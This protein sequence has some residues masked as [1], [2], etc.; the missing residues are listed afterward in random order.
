[1]DIENN[2]DDSRQKNLPKKKKQTIFNIAARKSKKSSSV[3][4]TQP[5]VGDTQTGLQP[6]VE[7]EVS[8]AGL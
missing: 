8:P 6:V 4:G 3:A 1:M 5:D 2:E 7:D